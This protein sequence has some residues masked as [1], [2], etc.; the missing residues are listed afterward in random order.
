MPFKVKTRSPNEV[1]FR[2]KTCI[3]NYS[4]T[5]FDIWIDRTIRM[6]SGDDCAKL[7]GLESMPNVKTVAYESDNTLT[8]RGDKPWTRDSGAL[9]IWILGMF[10]HSDETTVVIPFRTGPEEQLGAIVNDAYFGKVP[11]DRLVVGDGVLYFK[12]DG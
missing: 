11:A 10:R 5:E 6:I 9:S 3:A 4:G 2:H 8:N 7:L 12:G 1:S